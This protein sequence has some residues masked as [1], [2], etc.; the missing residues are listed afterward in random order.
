MQGTIEA[1]RPE[2][3]R[4]NP[5]ALNDVG[6]VTI[7]GDEHFTSLPKGDPYERSRS[8]WVGGF[9]GPAREH[10]HDYYRWYILGGIVAA[11]LLVSLIVT[12][13]GNRKEVLISGVFINNST[14]AEGYSHLQ[15]GYFD[16][17]GGDGDTRVDL[18]EA[19][20]L[21][22][23]SGALSQSDAAS[24][25]MVASMIAART[26]DYIITDEPS[27]DHFIEQ[28]VVLDL[29]LAL[30]DEQLAKYDVIER[31]GVPVAIRLNGTACAENYP[32]TSDTGCVFLAASTEDYEKDV[33]FLEYLLADGQRTPS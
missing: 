4:N 6:S 29:R 10:I 31:G 22:F 8:V 3:L 12:I 20:Y 2:T 25:M 24:F 19:R 21:D 27:L 26:L 9:Q 13:A 16:Y 28:E 1:H 23:E 15:Q 32:L 5:G 11:V 30:S 18:V 33:R 17:C 7:A 14:T